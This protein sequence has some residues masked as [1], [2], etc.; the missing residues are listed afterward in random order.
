MSAAAAPTPITPDPVVTNSTLASF[1]SAS[2]CSTAF[3]GCAASGENKKRQTQVTNQSR[4]SLEDSGF[5]VGDCRGNKAAWKGCFTES[6]DVRRGWGEFE[7]EGGEFALGGGFGF[8]A[9]S[10]AIVG[11][12]VVR[13]EDEAGIG[14]G[15]AAALPTRIQDQPCREGEPF[16]RDVNFNGQSVMMRPQHHP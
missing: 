12:P 8:V 11:S 2:G 15:K 4:C 5:F 13:F 7:C 1:R 3:P 6:G 10:D 9:G 16:C 14:G